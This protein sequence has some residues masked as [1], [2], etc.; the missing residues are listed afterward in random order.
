LNLGPQQGKCRVL[1][2]APPWNYQALDSDY[3]IRRQTRRRNQGQQDLQ[4]D[5]RFTDEEL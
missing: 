2:T 4:A 5:I 1:T 3:C